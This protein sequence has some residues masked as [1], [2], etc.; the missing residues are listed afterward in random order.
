MYNAVPSFAFPWLQNRSR[1]RTPSAQL[2]LAAQEGFSP[3]YIALSFLAP[4]HVFCVPHHATVRLC[5]CVCM[6]VHDCVRRV[7]SK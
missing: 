4:R 1:T 5:V 7:T 3:L 6:C 2:L